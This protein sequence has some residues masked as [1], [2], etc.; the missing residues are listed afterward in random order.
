MDRQ[1][2]TDK[3]VCRVRSQNLILGEQ[4]TA[5]GTIT[6]LCYTRAIV[7]RTTHTLL[8]FSDP[9][10]ILTKVYQLDIVSALAYTTRFDSFNISTQSD[11]A[12]DRLTPSF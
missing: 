2:L 5:R 12:S 10:Q 9:E 1:V 6:F 8:I 4:R 7:S 3:K 11:T